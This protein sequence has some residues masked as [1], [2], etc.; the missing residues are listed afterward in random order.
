[1]AQTWKRPTLTLV[2]LGWRWLAGIPLILWA[3]KWAQPHLPE[4]EAIWA[5]LGTMTFFHPAEMAATIGVS[6]RQLLAIA[7]PLLPVFIPVAVLWWVAV[8]TFGQVLYARRTLGAESRASLGVFFVLR[9][10]RSLGVMLCWTIWLNILLAVA[11]RELHT[12]ATLGAE[13]DVLVFAAL[14]IVAT[15]ALFVG[16][17]G[18]SWP[19][20]LAMNWNAVHGDSLFASL[21]SAV[22]QRAVRAEV[23]EIALVMCIVKLA[24]L[25]LALTFSATPLPFSAVATPEFLRNWW[26]GLIILYSFMSDY[27]HGVRFR[28][29][30]VVCRDLAE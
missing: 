29:Y 2:E 17:A 21:R 3:L 23:M 27:F 26:I 6:S 9:L 16:W 13:P 15:L 18:I 19:L 10:V 22:T 12:T 7:R 4:L 1:M 11:H 30:S 14:S 5:Q 20:T 24:L 25:V 8:G 28:Y